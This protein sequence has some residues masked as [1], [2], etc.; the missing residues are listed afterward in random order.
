MN[1]GTYIGKKLQHFKNNIDSPLA[2]ILTLNTFAHTVGAIGVGKQATLIWHDSNPL[3]TGVIVPLMMTMAILILSEIIPKTIGANFWESLATFTVYCLSFLIKILYPLVWLCQL[4]TK[5][6]RRDK[7]KSIFSR[8][9]FVAL[10]EIGEKQGVL[11]AGESE[12]IEKAL[13]LSELRVTEVMRP[14]SDMI[15][16]NKNEN[17]DKL[18]E[19]V[20][21]YRYSRYPVYDTDKNEIVGMLHVKNFLATYDSLKEQSVNDFVSPVLK[22]SYNLPVN[23]LLQR[24]REGMAHFALVYDSNNKLLGF[25]TLDNVLH[26]LLGIIKDEFNRTHVDWVLN[27]DGTISATGFCSIYSLE[28]A[29]DIDIEDDTNTKTLAGLILHHLERFPEKGEIINF[30]EFD[31]KIEKIV[32]MRISNVTIYPKTANTHKP[33]NSI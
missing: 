3:I 9:D 26:V 20:K 23:D 30:N 16:I 14:A 24:F 12:I 11:E 10:A 6:F 22:V 25:I 8:T 32:D 5:S 33:V 21:K 17:V 18:L 27:K 1:E 13:D 7:N 4:I 19:L 2:A 28:Q 15:M 29:L 31:I